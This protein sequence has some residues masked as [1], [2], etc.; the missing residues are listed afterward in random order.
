ML[1]AVIPSER[2]QPAVPLAGQLAHQRFVRPGPL[3]LGTAFL[4]SPARAADRDRHICYRNL[5]SSSPEIGAKAFLLGSACRH[6]GRTISSP[7]SP[8]GVRRIVSE[9]SGWCTRRYRPPPFMTS[10]CAFRRVNPFASRC[11]PSDIALTMLA[12]VTNSRCL[13]LISG[14]RSKNGM[15]FVRRS[16]RRRTTN[17]NVVS[18]EP[19]WFSRMVPQPSRLR[20]RWRTSAREASWLT[21][22]SGTS[23]QPIRVVG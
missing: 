1:S 19:R 9:D 5:E 13:P 8:S 11:A 2:S 22:N 4:K 21:W 20:M 7:D 12:K 14:C 10:A 6:A 17:T 3:V 18:R 15:T 16:T 23:C